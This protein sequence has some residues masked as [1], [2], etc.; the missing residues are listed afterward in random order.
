MAVTELLGTHSVV[1]GTVVSGPVGM[2]VSGPTGTVD[3][4]PT[5]TVPLVQGWVE[6]GAVSVAVTGQ[7][8][9]LTAMV[10]VETTVLWAGQLVTSGPQ[11]VTVWTLV[12]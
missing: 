7:M 4:G 8:V 11:E 6:A 10:S 5:G 12:V 3:S 9:V 2:V 1:A